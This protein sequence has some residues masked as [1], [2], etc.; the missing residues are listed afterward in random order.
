MAVSERSIDG[1]FYFAAR[2]ATSR[3]RGAPE[4]A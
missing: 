3:D 1:S 4:S 2:A